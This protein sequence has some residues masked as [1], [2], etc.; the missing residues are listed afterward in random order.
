MHQVA[1]SFESV[2]VAFNYGLDG[3]MKTKARID[4]LK[5]LDKNLPAFLL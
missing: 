3:Y 1:G 4:R 5:S 2:D